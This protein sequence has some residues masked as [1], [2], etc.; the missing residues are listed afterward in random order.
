MANGPGRSWLVYVG[1]DIDGHAEQEKHKTN[2]TLYNEFPTI[3]R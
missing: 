2:T 1:E 3:A